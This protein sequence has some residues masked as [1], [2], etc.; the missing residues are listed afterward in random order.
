MSNNNI[1]T[2]Y[3]TITNIHGLLS[4]SWLTCSSWI[5][6]SYT[7]VY[8]YIIIWM[9]PKK[10]YPDL[11]SILDWNFPQHKLSIGRSPHS[12]KP[13][14]ICHIWYHLY[15]YIYL[16]KYKYIDIYIYVYVNIYMYICIYPDPGWYDPNRWYT[17]W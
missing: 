4:W 1:S 6:R 7:Y 13:P 11:S 16:Y 5:V 14:Y 15:I 17:Y 12:R 9:F 3:R 10:G 8:I 2:Y